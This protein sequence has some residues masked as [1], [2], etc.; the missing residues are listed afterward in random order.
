[1]RIPAELG[2]VHPRFWREPRVSLIEPDVALTDFG[3]AAECALFAGW[4]VWRGSTGSPLGRWSVVLFA[5]LGLGAL[6]G[7]ITHGFLPDAGSDAAR[8]AWNA[9]LIA[10]GVAAWASWAVG[11]HVLLVKDTARWVVAAAALLFALNVA[12]VLHVSQSFVVAIAFYAPAIVFALI[13]FV[14]AY[15][16]SGRAVLLFAIAGIVLSLI[17]AVIQQ[18][19]AGIAALG[20]SHNALY[21]VVQAVGLLLIFLTARGLG[22]AGHEPARLRG[23]H[24]SRETH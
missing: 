11:A 23:A 17:A 14:L 7:G 21:H 10:I 5:A 9:T 12:V 24:V 15:R 1:M 3:L 2:T 18:T 22:G 20:L 13:A 4:L 19:Q 16:A 6:L 8:M